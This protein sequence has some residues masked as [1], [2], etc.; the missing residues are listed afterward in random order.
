MEL[1]SNGKYFRPLTHTNFF[2]FFWELL[3]PGGSDDRVCLQSGRPGF[4]PW[5]GK[6]PL[7]KG[8]ATHSSIHA[9]RGPR[10]EEPGELQSL[11]LQR[12]RRDWATI[13]HT[14]TTPGVKMGLPGGSVGKESAWN[15]GYPGSIPRSGRSSGE[16]IGNPLQYSCLGWTEEPGGLHAVARIWQWLSN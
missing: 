16:G 6:T 9:W 15:A 1:I 13:T 12:V 11:G 4:I 5:V 10:T 3:Y 14:H 8:M 7:E 2:F